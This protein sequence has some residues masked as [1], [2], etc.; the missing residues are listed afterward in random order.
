MKNLKLSV[1]ALLV[2][3]IGFTTFTSCETPVDGTNGIDGVNGTDGTNG[4]NGTDGSDAIMPLTA[5]KTPN[6]LKVTSD[7][8]GL[9]ITPILSS[10]DVIPNS[11]NFVYGS[12]ADGSGLLPEVDGTFT[13]I[14]NIEADYAIARI[15]LNKNL[16]P[17]AAEYILNATATGETA[18]CSGSMITPGEHG[19]G[20][21]Y[22]SGGEWGGASKGVFVTDPYKSA[23][24][25][26]TGKMLTAMGQWS[27]ENAVVIGKDAYADKT[28]AFIGD[29]N[30]NNEIPSG[31]LGMYVGN[32]G[33]LEGGK[34]YGL[35]VTSANVSYEV[36]MKQGTS[37]DAKFV[38]LEERE[39]AALDAECKTKGVMG[40]SR[41]ED[42]DWR[43]GSAANN[44]EIYFAVT[45]RNKPGLVGKGAILGR[46]YKVVL[47]E[48][49]PTGAAKITCVLDADIV[50]G[51]ADGFHSP[52]NIVVTENYAYIQED[53]NGYAAVNSA[54]VGYSK[55]YQYNLNTGV[56]KTVLECD[57]ERA[58][59]LGYG[60]TSK[61]WEITGMVD[62]TDIVNN[63][64]SSFLVTTQNHGWEPA[65]GT[66]FTD[67]KAN[68]DLENRKEGSVLHLI[69]GL[70]R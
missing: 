3:S 17:F 63:G 52:D 14:N 66:S 60:R 12:M 67:P 45:G 30:A 25:A 28:V 10:E 50:G 53:P 32:R 41:L 8:V 19:F 22:L 42:I 58:A 7:F 23:S 1:F 51:K 69:T 34:L 36:D 46:V 27:T 68:T 54:I 21:L 18:Q 65:D 16:R 57:Q 49:D 59:S 24:Q 5:S 62:V 37:Y 64:T 47:N 26:S 29:D 9:K 11:P 56:V 15:K 61:Y 20:P 2:I 13:L 55:L 70:E 33:D 44:R 6:F 4:T 35:K 38:E 40:F 39:I 31:Q 43:R 48:N